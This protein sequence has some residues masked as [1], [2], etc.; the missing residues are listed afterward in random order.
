MTIGIVDLSAH[1]G[2]APSV[3]ALLAGMNAFVH[4]RA[5]RRWQQDVLR[6]GALALASPLDGRRFKAD[7]TLWLEETCFAYRLRHGGEQLWLVTGGCATGWHALGL[8]LPA[9]GIGF[10][11]GPDDVELLRAPSLRR[12]PTLKSRHLA[13][14]RA[15]NS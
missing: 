1:G 12:S 10:A 5:L 3:A 11:A 2:P 9:A 4:P 15:R 7:A 14:R 6:T 13:T 8:V